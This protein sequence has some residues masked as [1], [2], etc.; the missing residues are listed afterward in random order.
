M[1]ALEISTPNLAPPT[2]EQIWAL[3]NILA[4]AMPRKVK[5]EVLY[6]VPLSVARELAD[7]LVWAQAW[8]AMYAAEQAVGAVAQ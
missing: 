6:P 4:S 3:A 1:S 2:Q 7:V 5:V 8:A